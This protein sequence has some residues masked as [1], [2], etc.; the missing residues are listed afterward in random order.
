MATRRIEISIR[1]GCPSTAGNHRHT[2]GSTEP[3]RFLHLLGRLRLCYGL[4][5]S[6]R[7]IYI[8]GEVQKIVRT[9]E[10]PFLSQKRLQLLNQP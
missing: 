4:R 7:T 5:R 6:A 9:G 3:H 8:I 10:K 2:R 1:V